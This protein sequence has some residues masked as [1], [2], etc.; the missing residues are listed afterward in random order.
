[1]SVERETNVR[2]SDPTKL[3]F[4][5]ERVLE[6]SDAWEVEHAARCF[7]AKRSTSGRR[8]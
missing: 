6:E 7:A 5:E 4:I 3:G 2:V 8:S 1:M